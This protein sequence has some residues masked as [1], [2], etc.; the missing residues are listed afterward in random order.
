MKAKFL[1]HPLRFF[2][3]NVADE[4]FFRDNGYNF[5]MKSM[6][7]ILQPYAKLGVCY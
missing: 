6:G 5:L 2:F 7:V 3:R 1:F 4:T